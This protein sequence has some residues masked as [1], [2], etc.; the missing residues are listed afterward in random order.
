MTTRLYLVSTHEKGEGD[1]LIEAATSAQALRHVASKMI[2]VKPAT[3]KEVAHLVGHG[4]K[5]E[6]LE[7]VNE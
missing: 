2:K 7:S 4:V 5:V 3:T 6:S 1:R